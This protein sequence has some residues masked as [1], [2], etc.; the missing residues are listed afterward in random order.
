MFRVL[1]ALANILDE[2]GEIFKMGLFSFIDKP[3]RTGR[4]QA[5]KAAKRAADAGEQNFQ[6]FFD[7]IKPSIEQGQQALGSLNS[8]ASVDGLDELYNSVSN[9]GLAQG[10]IADQERSGRSFLA[11][12]G[13]RRSGAGAKSFSE[14]PSGVISAL[15]DKVIGGQQNVASLGLGQGSTGIGALSG[16]NQSLG[17]GVD[18][19]NQAR[20][21]RGNIIGGLLS[22]GGNLGAAALAP[23]DARLKTNIKKIAQIKDVNV[24]EWDWKPGIEERIGTAM[25]TGFIA[26]EVAETHPQ[27]VYPVDIEGV[28]VLAIDYPSLLEELEYAA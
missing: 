16:I 5:A 17:I 20:D 25:N 1:Y 2:L 24:Y 13:L 12:S 27:H 23:S 7:L 8:F 21:A 9:S 19:A 4:T 3:I 18:G 6:Q 26:Q 28:E 15:M 10:L 22:A 11:S 14:I